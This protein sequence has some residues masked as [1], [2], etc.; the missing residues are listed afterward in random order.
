MNPSPTVNEGVIRRVL[1][2]LRRAC[3]PRFTRRAVFTYHVQRALAVSPRRGAVANDGLQIHALSA[4][5]Q[6]EWTARFVHPWD[7]DLPQEER[8]G[9]FVYQCLH[10]VDQAIA[11]LFERFDVVDELD[12]SVLDPKSNARIVT[13][14]VTRADYLASRPLTTQMRLKTVGL[15]YE[16]GRGGLQPLG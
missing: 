1:S 6:I 9:L 2:A 13:G 8:S 7:H 15:A 16:I 11:Q 5:M 14:V 4:R 3:R 12:I 10:D